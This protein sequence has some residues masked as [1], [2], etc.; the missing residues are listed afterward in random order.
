M[1]RPAGAALAALAALWV[2]PAAAAPPEAA[3]P[4]SGYTSCLERG[5][6]PAARGAEERRR[7][8]A[9]RTVRERD[10]EEAAEWTRRFDEL[11]QE[12]RKEIQLLMEQKYQER[13]RFLS[14]SYERAIQD[15][16]VLERKELKEAIAQHEAL[17]A[18][19]PDDPRVVPDAMLRLAELYSERSNEEYARRLAAWREQE[20]SAA[21]A[22]RELTRVPV[23]DYAP[24]IALYR[25]IIA[26][27]GNAPFLH[28]VYYLLGYSLGE[29]GEGEQARRVFLTLV[30]R[31][32]Q[33]PYVPEA[34]V[35]LGDWYFDEGKPGS[36]RRAAEAFSKVQAHP[37][38]PLY[39]RAT[40][41]LGWTQYRLDEFA[42]AVDAFVKL[43]DFYVKQSQKSGRPPT[44]EVWPEAV[45]YTAVS[46][47]DRRWG[48]PAKARLY[49]ES[50]GGRPYE[51]EVYQRLGDVLF[52]E[53]R[54]AQAVEAYQLALARSPL[55]QD[56]PRIQARIVIAWQRDHRADR[57]ADARERLVTA[58]DEHGAWWQ[59]NQAAPDL[60]NEVRDLREKGLMVAA[61]THHAQAQAHKKA[62]KLD[63]A[64]PEY[65]QAARVYGAYLS[66]FPHSLNA[67]DMTYRQ[68]DCLYNSGDFARAAQA[69]ADVRDDPA[70]TAHLA[71]AGLSAVISW[72]S[73]VARLRA[74][75]Q[76][77]DRKPLRSTERPAGEVP[78][79]EALPPALVELVRASD[80]LLA[81]IP[82]HPRGPA[83]AY[84]AGEVFYAHDQFEEARCRLEEVMARWPRAEVAQYAANLVIESHLAVK[85][86]AAV[87]TAAAQLQKTE[88]ASS[89]QLDASL[90]KFK[91]GGRFNRA[92][93]LME[94]KQYQEAARLFAALVA[95]DPRHEFADKALYNAASCLE[96]ARRFES[97]LR[98]YERVQAEYPGSP[99]ADDALFRVA[100]NAENTYDFD[101]AVDRYLLLVDRYPGSRHRKD[102]LYNAARS[103]ENLQRY[104]AAAGAFA[105]Y[106]RLYPAAE[107]AARTQY[108]A[109]LIYE[110]TREWPRVVKGMQD[111]RSRFARSTEAELL[112]QSHLETAGAW[113]E[114]GNEKA[115]R[116]GYRATVAEFRKRG[117]DPEAQPAAA[118]AAAEAQFRLA[119]IEF[120][121]YDRIQLPATADQGKLK[122]ALQKKLGELRK[123][124]PLYD[125]VKGYQRPDWTLAAFYRQAYSLERLAQTLYDA[126]PPPE[127]KRKG[128][129]EYLAAYQ[130]R[131]A[132]YAQPYEERAV[133]V[134]VQ[135]LT[136]ARELHVKN[137][138]TRK[139][140]ESLAR[141]R[142]REYP[143]LKEPKGRLLLEDRAPAPLVASPEGAGPA[144]AVA[145]TGP[146][147]PTP[148]DAAGQ[149]GETPADKGG[150][151]TRSTSETRRP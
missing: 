55:S 47:S 122:S 68:A 81:K 3:A 149:A 42:R 4:A 115:A 17:L 69:Y 104:D 33:S 21:A 72:E 134:Y 86:W 75:G 123:V 65:R 61:A 141:Y 150:D 119:E 138:W 99:F 5:A 95:E 89:P 107:D 109:A 59:A 43:L 106:A 31:Y 71:E 77:P 113:R 34:W 38:H 80:A 58:Y 133:E 29:T 91:L 93:Q 25:R 7:A 143:V 98:L 51:A 97:A 136:A 28:A 82:Q 83:I 62:G 102:A 16:E 50:L 39:P 37:D 60:L 44:G 127:F 145:R 14:E 53:T 144:G 120:Q 46:F 84:K 90:Q 121:R 2:G 126:P 108:H 48:G 35:R 27:Y 79:P 139:I 10:L 129:E 8:P 125:E 101:K 124:A 18:R 19:Y 67:Y 52:D 23:K 36:L 22:G 142:P 78:R 118:A 92:T 112:V 76:L 128:R 73:E 137:E 6:T 54:Y 70:G 74:A 116:Q 13:R 49:F 105:R 111:F 135:A 57:E 94:Q 15:L 151:T 24:S 56:A 87:E 114:L 117:L 100:W 140:N 132:E 131:L 110:K 66:R 32:P 64:I 30:D 41:K 88:V 103:L 130:D 1:A 63:L 147:A 146:T 9:E 26:R 85:D 12:Y 148:P 11:T 45:Q 20:R 96:S 40:Y